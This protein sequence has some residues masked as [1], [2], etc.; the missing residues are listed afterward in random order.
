MFFP[1]VRMALVMSR[2]GIEL[3]PDDALE[4]PA[5][6]GHPGLEGIEGDVSLARRETDGHDPAGR[7]G[8]AR[9]DALGRTA[10]VGFPIRAEH[11]KRDELG[12]GTPLRLVAVGAHAPPPS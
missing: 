6:L 4:G 5:Y 7:L 12:A 1:S 11:E 2:S 8:H 3:P 9:R 10:H